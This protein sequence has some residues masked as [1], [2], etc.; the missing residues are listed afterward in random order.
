M[1]EKNFDPTSVDSSLY[2]KCYYLTPDN[3]VNITEGNESAPPILK[4]S[5]RHIIKTLGD[6]A[7]FNISYIVL[8]DYNPNNKVLRLEIIPY[9]PF[10]ANASAVYR[11]YI[12]K[13]L[14]N[15]DVYETKFYEGYKDEYFAGFASIDEIINP[16]NFFI[17]K[18]VL[19]NTIEVDYIVADNTI[20][21]IL[22][23]IAKGYEAFQE[24]SIANI[25]FDDSSFKKLKKGEYDNIKRSVLPTD[26]VYVLA[27][28]E[29]NGTN[30]SAEPEQPAETPRRRRRTKEG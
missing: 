26:N 17:N 10:T 18:D 16:K 22:A 9:D 30:E 12:D 1:E 19:G 4:P 24:K 8:K 5:S 27:T 29:T 3:I 2:K 11:E 28:K 13:Y 15:D 14:L 25:N 21:N 23:T 6:F 7:F 20:E